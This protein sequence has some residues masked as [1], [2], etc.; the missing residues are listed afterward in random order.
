MKIEK[1]YLKELLNRVT[2]KYSPSLGSFRD[3]DTR[4]LKNL[5]EHIFQHVPHGNINYKTLRRYQYF[6]KDSS[7]IDYNSRIQ[8]L[9]ILSKYLD[10][11]LNWVEFRR[12]IRDEGF[13]IEEPFEFTDSGILASSIFRVE[14]FDFKTNSCFV[15]MP[16]TL[17]WSDRIWKHLQRIMKENGF[18]CNRADNLY[19]AD[20]LKDIWKA[21][22]ESEIIIADTTS[23]NPNVFYEIGIAHALGKKVVLITQNIDDI[24]F[25]FRRF[26]HIHYEDN[27]DGIG[28]LENEIP[29]YLR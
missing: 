8:I 25:D 19:G 29:N 1:P 7:K 20:V 14:S 12:R 28:I 5:S 17:K 16:F 27:T 15:L 11:E 3:L 26:R 2:K 4:E 6:L 10:K 24:P 13:V 23:K 21:I 18:S 9:D 22:R